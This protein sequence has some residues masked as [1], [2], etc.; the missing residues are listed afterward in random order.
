[1]TKQEAEIRHDQDRTVFNAESD[2]Q[3]KLKGMRTMSLK[4][5]GPKAFFFSARLFWLGPPALW[6]CDAKSLTYY[7]DRL[8]RAI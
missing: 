2:K 7:K 5:S 6:P 8:E 4:W 3:D 1:M